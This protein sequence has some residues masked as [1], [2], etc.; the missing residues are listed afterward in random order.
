LRNGDPPSLDRPATGDPVTWDGTM[1]L[2]QGAVRLLNLIDFERPED[3]IL[4]RTIPNQIRWTSITHGDQDGLRVLLVVPQTEGAPPDTLTF[5]AGDYRRV[6]AT[7]DLEG[8]NEVVDVT[9][10]LQVSLRAVRADPAVSASGFLRGH[11]GWAPGDSVGRFQGLWVRAGDGRLEGVVRGHYGIDARNASVFY[12]K[13]IDVAGHFRGFL[14]GTWAATAEGAVGA[15]GFRES[16]TFSGHWVDE[17]GSALGELSGRWM[18][19]GDHTGVFS[20]DWKALGLA[21]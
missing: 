12:G 9:D 7:A 18:R 10:S 16:G 5:Q 1:A 2:S 14:R 20:G 13:Y 8:L 17:K 4:P 6:I 15:P 21:P 11:W 19:R 3:R